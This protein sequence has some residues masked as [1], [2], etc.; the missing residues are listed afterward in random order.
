MNSLCAVWYYGCHGRIPAGTWLFGDAD[1]RIACWCLR[2]PIIVD[3]Y[4]FP[5][6]R[7]VSYTAVAVSDVSGKLVD[8]DMCACNLLCDRA[9]ENQQKACSTEFGTIKCRYILYA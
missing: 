8:H 2:T 7:A 4:I 9:A 1:D 5:R 6:V 3:I